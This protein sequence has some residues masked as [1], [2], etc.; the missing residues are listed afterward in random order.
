M[1]QPVRKALPD[2]VQFVGQFI[3]GED[4]NICGRQRLIHIGAERLD[5]LFRRDQDRE[6]LQNRQVKIDTNPGRA[7]IEQPSEVLAFDSLLGAITVL[8]TCI[9]GFTVKELDTGA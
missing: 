1:L 4:G 5:A 7:V 8:Q 2:V 3:A 9:G 6:F